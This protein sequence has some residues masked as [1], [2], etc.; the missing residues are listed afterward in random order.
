MAAMMLCFK[1]DNLGRVWLAALCLHSGRADCPLCYWRYSL[2]CRWR[3]STPTAG[4]VA[5]CAAVA[6]ACCAAGAECHCAAGATA[7]C[8]A[9]ATAR[10]LL[11]AHLPG[12]VN[13]HRK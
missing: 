11:Q 8:A 1:V 10:H 9:G 4:A 12:S 7:R 2:L 3:Y 6:T 13:M 5:R